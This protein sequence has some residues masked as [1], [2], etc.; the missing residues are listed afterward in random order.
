MAPSSDQ[1]PLG[2]FRDL[3][4]ELL[5]EPPRKAER[6]LSLPVLLVDTA[7]NEGV[8]TTLT[9]ELVP[10]G[11]GGLYPIP[12]LALIRDPDF[13][14]AEYEARVY[15]EEVG[16]WQ[17]GRDVRWRL[18]RCDGKPIVNLTGPSIGAAAALGIVKLFAE[19]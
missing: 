5:G 8:V 18:Q 12:V 11:S 17:K 6:D 7:R 3:T 1:L 16:L 14:R 13:R 10:H 2:F 9:L 4:Q 19:E 15:G